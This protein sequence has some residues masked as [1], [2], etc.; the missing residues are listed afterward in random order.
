MKDKVKA[1]IINYGNELLIGRIVN[2]NANWLASRLTE[3]GVFIN[4][5]TVLSDD[6]NDIK[7]GFSEAIARKTDLIIT[8]GGLGPTWDDRTGEGLAQA[9]NLPLIRNEDALNMIQNRYRSLGISINPESKKMADLPLGSIP[10]YNSVGTAPAIKF[11]KDYSTIYCVPGVPKEMKA[12]FEEHIS[13]EVK[14]MKGLNN[15]YQ[16]EFNIIGLGESRL[17]HITQDLT[18]KYPQ[19]YI[20]SHPKQ[21][22]T[23]KGVKSLIT[24]HLTTFGEENFK[25]DLENVAEILKKKLREIGAEFIE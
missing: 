22:M 24:F 6:Y 9:L 18:D 23:S 13:Q 21:E 15:F 7:T 11:Q 4:R 2:T 1:E 20:K 3:L 12:I 10:L 25:K 16:T 8:T 19:I 17:A 5:I 14:L